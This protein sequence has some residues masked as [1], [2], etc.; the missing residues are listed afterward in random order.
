[1]RRRTHNMVSFVFKL[2]TDEAKNASVTKSI[3]DYAKQ[4]G[5]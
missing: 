3:I 4:S 1:M 2:A 5:I